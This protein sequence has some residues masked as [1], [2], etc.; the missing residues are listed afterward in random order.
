VHFVALD[1]GDIAL[2]KSYVSLILFMYTFFHTV[3]TIENMSQTPA[4][5]LTY[6]HIIDKNHPLCIWQKIASHNQVNSWLSDVQKKP[7]ES[8]N[9]CNRDGS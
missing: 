9:I 4:P 2:L 7:V 3:Y 5:Q 1:E 6:M 8:I